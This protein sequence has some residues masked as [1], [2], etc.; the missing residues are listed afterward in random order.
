MPT[1]ASTNINNKTSAR[2]LGEKAINLSIHHWDGMI[3]GDD[4]QI[5]IVVQGRDAF[6]QSS[7]SFLVRRGR[8]HRRDINPITVLAERIEQTE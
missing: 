6:T 2:H 8:R 7:F 3:A 4:G 1:P 5:I